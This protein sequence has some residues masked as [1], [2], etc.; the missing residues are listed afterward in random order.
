MRA[1]VE[2]ARGGALQ[3]S[4][5]SF[6]LAL[7]RRSNVPELVD[8]L[9]A[10][11]GTTYTI[12]R[13][14]GG[15]GMSRVFVADDVALQRPVVIKV[16]HPELAAGVN[17]DRFRR[18]VQLLARLQHPHIV[19]ILSAG[20]VDG[21]PYYVMPFVRGESLRAR[22]EK[23]PLAPAEAAGLLA[24]VA[25]A[26]S[27]AHADGIVHRDI[28]PDNILIS[29]GAAVVAD[30]GIAKALSSA[31]LRG[32]SVSLT[33]LGTS[34]GTPAYM[35]PEQVAGDPNVDARA[36]LYSLGCVGYEALSGAP[37]FAGLS[38]QQTLAAQVIQKPA[39]IGS[40]RSGIPPWL[41]AVVM[42]C[43]EK[44]P[45]KRP[46]SAEELA[47]RLDVSAATDPRLSVPRFTRGPRRRAVWL[48]VAGL[49]AIGLLALGAYRW[50]RTNGPSD[51]GVAV[52]V[53]PFEVLDPKLALWREGMVDVLS[54]NIDGAGP[55]R[56]ISPTVAI[57]QWEGRADRGSA[58]VFASRVGA[59][60]VLYGQLQSAG[61][62]L[63]DAK[64]WIA[65]AGGDA[66]PIEVQVRDSSSR[67][68]RVT[69]SLSV[70]VL[71]VIGRE[72]TIGPARLAS[73]GSGSLPA[74]KAF[75]Q[76]SQYFR[77]TQWDSAVTSFQEA[78]ALDSNFAIAWGMLGQALGWTEGSGGGTDA[79][80][81]A[82]RLI[83]PGLSP[84]DSLLLTAM[85]HYG[86]ARNGFDRASELRQAFGAAEAAV[87]RYPDDAPVLYEYADMRYHGD[88]SLSDDD[89]AL[90]FDRAVAADSDFA[91]AW[92]H[93]VELSFRR[94]PDVGRRYA[95]TFLARNPR[96]AEAR[97]LQVAAVLAD[98]SLDPKKR[99]AILDTVSLDVIRRA[100]PALLQ[101][102]DS[103]EMAIAVAREGLRRSPPNM[104]VQVQTGLAHALSL[105]GHIAE[106]WS[107][108]VEVPNYLAAEIA[109]LGLI[110]A[111]S[112]A[113]VLRPWLD[114]RGDASI[115][116]IPVLALV[117]D[118][119]TLV[120]M[121]ARFD[122]IAAIAKTPAQRAILLYIAAETR[123]YTALARSDTATARRLFDTLPDSILVIP[124]DELM[125]ARL[126]E[127]QDPR[128]ALVLLQGKGATD[129]LTATRALERA[130]LAEQLGQRELAV[131]SY[132][133]V[134]DLWRNA[135]A[136]QLRAARDE[137]R[138]ALQRLDA[139]GR[140]RGTLS[141]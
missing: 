116:P 94:G 50:R 133:R 111:D 106:A 126:Q 29:G 141:P 7:T 53:A 39:P 18:E 101:L 32:D 95:S 63:V 76:G 14:L 115:A 88:P 36:D 51:A 104:R 25:K 105:R 118:T 109:G 130:R 87:Q 43:L 65:N 122:S 20:D 125:R 86:A 136:P 15:G 40:R 16:L 138:T 56:A 19:P 44:E 102:A 107:I 99:S 90:L 100:L 113:R 30:F 81:R 82:G 79:Y 134:A 75:L 38:P 131:E 45:A 54:R 137:A 69:D 80:A 11:L 120:R 89:A 83:R 74:I 127:R 93:A 71:G 41:E 22:L 42:Q 96:D 46:Q 1:S 2:G 27:A 108:S 21:L 5:A 66:S 28:K 123:A 92:V 13:E 10:A 84:R 59:Q 9:R 117:H 37:P 17:V 110:P 67:M 47:A 91:P 55:L 77:R 139:D 23:G 135:D 26:L 6:R 72:H 140:L 112:A 114:R 4:A 70:R 121:T 35:A 33:S 34:L 129:L 57:K 103:A 61:Q 119:A 60:I 68:D 85:A 132:A 8:R 64:V 24:D 49:V 78:V 73:L 31:Q 98:P 128:R 58:A 124:L 12:Q 52:A 48:A 97:G 3:C 62:D